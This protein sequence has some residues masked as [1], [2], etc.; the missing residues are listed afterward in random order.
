MDLSDSVRQSS[1]NFCFQ[2]VFCSTGSDFSYTYV[3]VVA[4]ALELGGCVDLVGHDPG[5]CLLNI[6]HPFDHLCLTHNVDIL[7]ERIILLP[8]SH[9]GV[10]VCPLLKKR[11]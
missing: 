4:L 3:E 6:L 11:L 1:L 10:L 9:L 8:E 5:D 2:Y 7:D